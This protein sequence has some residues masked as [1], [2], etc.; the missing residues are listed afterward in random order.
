MLGDYITVSSESLVNYLL[1]L[2]DNV[3]NRKVNKKLDFKVLQE[4]ILNN[5]CNIYKC[6]RS[7]IEKNRIYD[8]SPTYKTVLTKVHELSASGL[9]ERNNIKGLD[10]GAIEYQLTSFGVYYAIKNYHRYLRTLNII[11]IKKQDKLFQFFLYPFISM[12][13][14]LNIDDEYLISSIFDFLSTIC[15]AIDFNL[16]DIKRIEHDGGVT[17]GVT[18]SI[19]LDHIMRHKGFKMFK[20]FSDSPFLQYLES[21]LGISWTDDN[22]I[23]VIPD[24]DDSGFKIIDKNREI[25]FKVF[26]NKNKA[27]LYENE[28]L[29]EEFGID[30]DNGN[31]TVTAFEPISVKEFYMDRLMN[32]CVSNIFEETDIPIQEL[33][34][35]IINHLYMDNKSSYIQ[36]KYKKLIVLLASDPN[37]KK[38][39]YDIEKDMELKIK[40]FKDLMN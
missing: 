27:V 29:I 6:H 38:C 1:Y 31:Y 18:Q 37:F 39:I 40:N 7:L 22:L 3:K 13:T 28:T 35:R 21:K 4:F 11:K 33:C 30:F 16:K 23:E 8:Y 9:I 34:W 17:Y 26:L 25:S 36:E 19:E 20:K 2:H 12:E 5:E 32:N 14:I 10:H 15:N 24:K